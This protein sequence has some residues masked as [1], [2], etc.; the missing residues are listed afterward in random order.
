MELKKLRPGIFF[1]LCGAEIS[2]IFPSET[3]K[4]NGRGSEKLSD[5]QK[6][7]SVSILT[8]RFVEFSPLVW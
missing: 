7:T 2:R 8:A 4:R 1:P 3:P 5:F 6:K